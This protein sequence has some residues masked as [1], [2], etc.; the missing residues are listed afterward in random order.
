[1]L[2]SG[3]TSL[4]YNGEYNFMIANTQDV[5]MGPLANKLMA[6]QINGEECQ[7][8]INGAGNKAFE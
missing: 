2:T 7:S 3:G 4:N 6:A 1:M 5:S 8:V